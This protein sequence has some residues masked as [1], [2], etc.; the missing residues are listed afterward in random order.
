MKEKLF[1]S[2]HTFQKRDFQVFPCF[3]VWSTRA[4]VCACVSVYM[5]MPAD[6]RSQVASK[7]THISAWKKV[8]YDKRPACCFTA[9]FVSTKNLITAQKS[10]HMKR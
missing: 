1:L 9:I 10:I 6:R 8:Q 5:C 3:S 4:C 7:C 2:F